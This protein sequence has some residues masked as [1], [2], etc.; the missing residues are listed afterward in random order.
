MIILHSVTEVL[1]LPV[2]AISFITRSIW[3]GVL[4]I[5]AGLGVVQAR[6]ASAEEPS[7]YVTCYAKPRDPVYFNKAEWQ[8]SSAMVNWARAERAIITY[9]SYKKDN[10]TEMNKLISTA[11]TAYHSAATEVGNGL[12]SKEAYDMAGEILAEWHKEMALAYTSVEC[13]EATMIQPTINDVS[14]RL[15]T[16]QQLS[17][18][19]KITPAAVEQAEQSIK[20]SLGAEL[21]SKASAELAQLLVELLGFNG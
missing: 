13:Y 3:T 5:L 10:F 1:L 20:E 7:K 15:F 6:N 17:M 8:N 16:L 9:A 2:L 11:R 14:G 12:L 4:A 19:G 21:S 18:E